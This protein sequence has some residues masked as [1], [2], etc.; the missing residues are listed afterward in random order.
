MQ[1]KAFQPKGLEPGLSW[2]LADLEATKGSEAKL[3][4]MMKN[5]WLGGGNSN[6]FYVHPPKIGEMIQF[7]EHIFTWVETSN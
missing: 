2:C 3:G 4:K 6:I 7:D 5:V 1:A